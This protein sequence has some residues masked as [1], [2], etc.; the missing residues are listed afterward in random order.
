MLSSVTAASANSVVLLWDLKSTPIAFKTSVAMSEDTVLHT[1]HLTD[2]DKN[3]FYPQFSISGKF[4]GPLDPVNPDTTTYQY[5]VDLVCGEIASPTTASWVYEYPAANK[6]LGTAAGW[7]VAYSV[8]ENNMLII[9]L[10]GDAFVTTVTLTTT[11]TVLP[12]DCVD[13]LTA[14]SARNQQ[15]GNYIS[16]AQIDGSTTLTLSAGKFLK[17]PVE[18][19]YC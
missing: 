9:Q 6:D 16:V 13:A 3:V 5:Q 11:E 4:L 15:A 14:G 7:G 1:I 18:L 8:D 12:T 17:L 10:S 19:D 2:A